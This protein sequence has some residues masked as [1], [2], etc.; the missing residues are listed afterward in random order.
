MER[1]IKVLCPHHLIEEEITLPDGY[2]EDF[3][4]DIPCGEVDEDERKV[5]YIELTENYVMTVR[6][7]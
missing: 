3:K 4:G 5:I 2:Y 6:E 1:N 7:K